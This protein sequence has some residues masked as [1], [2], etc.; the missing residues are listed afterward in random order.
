MTLE[1]RD[2]VAGFLAVIIG[3]FVLAT[4]LVVFV[5]ALNGVGLPDVWNSLFGLV[6]ALVSALGGY[7]AGA[8]MTKRNGNG[9]GGAHHEPD[10]S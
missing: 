5:L 3:I 10:A 9:N 2:R 1:P 7:M 8:S 4:L 6:V